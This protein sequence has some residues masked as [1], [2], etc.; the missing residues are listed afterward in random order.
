[1]FTSILHL[2]PDMRRVMADAVI[3]V[4]VLT[5][6]AVAHIFVQFVP[7]IRAGLCLNTPHMDRLC[8]LPGLR[9]NLFAGV[10]T[11][12]VDKPFPHPHFFILLSHSV[13]YRQVSRTSH[14]SHPPRTSLQILCI[15]SVS[16]SFSTGF[17]TYPMLSFTIS[18]P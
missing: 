8:Y 17:F 7:V 10:P 2:L 5:P 15:S 1:M 3:S 16:V 13:P 14:F 4:P 9:K 18:T 6:A 12:P 11:Q